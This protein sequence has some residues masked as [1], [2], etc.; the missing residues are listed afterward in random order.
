[1]VTTWTKRGR[2]RASVVASVL[3]LALGMTGCASWFGRPPTIP[4]PEFP[5]AT[6]EDVTWLARRVDYRE[7]TV[8]EAERFSRVLGAVAYCQEAEAS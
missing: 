8:I 1:M 7:L 2:L 5:C 4:K 6:D 3:A